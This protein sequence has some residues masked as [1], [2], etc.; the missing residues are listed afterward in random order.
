MGRQN[1]LAVFS[2]FIHAPEMRVAEVDPKA[3]DNAGHQR[4]LFGGADWAADA[5]G[6]VRRA[7][8]PRLHVFHGLRQ[9]KLL[10]RIIEMNLKTRSC[11]LDHILF[12]ELRRH[13]QDWP[14]QRGVVPP[15]GGDFA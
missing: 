3:I 4:K 2:P 7:L 15:V 8:P 13:L 11:E 12:V 9:I 10:Q 14:I 6:I 1:R 5:G